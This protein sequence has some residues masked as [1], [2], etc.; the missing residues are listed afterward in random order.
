MGVDDSDWQFWSKIS[1]A[2]GRPVGPP[3][4]EPELTS[5]RDGCELPVHIHLDE[6]SER[7]ADLLEERDQLRA[8]RDQL[9]AER[10]QA[11]ETN[12]ALHRRVQ[13]AEADAEERTKKKL[14]WERVSFVLSCFDYVE[15]QLRDAQALR[16]PMSWHGHAL[17]A[18]LRSQIVEAQ[19]FL[20][21]EAWIGENFE[22]NE[23]FKR[24]SRELLPLDPPPANKVCE[25]LREAVNLIQL[26]LY[27]H[28]NQVRQDQ[29][30]SLI[31][32][33]WDLI[34]A[35]NLRHLMSDLLPE[36]AADGN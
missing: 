21:G 1:F 25:L 26:E 10:D 31:K 24:T 6:D 9:R 16:F 28:P 15:A 7:E 32:R 22:L 4:R 17:L 13:R 35:E 14:N 12:R 20:A 33:T 29:A 8:E 27:H 5:I 36:G 30:R 34:E 3:L 11:R 2:V 18:V 23:W 19:E